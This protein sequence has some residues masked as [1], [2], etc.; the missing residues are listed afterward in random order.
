MEPVKLK[1][2]DIAIIKRKL[3]A[4]QS[5]ACPL[6][7]GDLTKIKPINVVVDH[8]HSTGRVRAALCRG[9]NGVE[10]K[11]KRLITTF[12]KTPNFLV[13]LQRLLNYWIHHSTPRTEWIH[14][15]HKTAEEQRAL[16]NKRARAAYAKKKAGE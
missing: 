6:C 4:M 16:R 7:G 14:P 11:V 13:F 15:T 1:Q 2:K 5:G 8:D 10:G 9:C 12:G 3:V